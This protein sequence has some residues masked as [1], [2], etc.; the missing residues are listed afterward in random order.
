ME[1]WWVLEQDRSEE[2][3]LVLRQDQDEELWQARKQD[4]E[5]VVRL[6]DQMKLVGWLDQEWVDELVGIEELQK[7]LLQGLLIYRKIFED[8]EWI[9]V[10]QRITEKRTTRD[11]I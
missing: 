6:V 11:A 10:A 9:E 7:E 8:F 5:L 3:W 4:M 1:F 2:L